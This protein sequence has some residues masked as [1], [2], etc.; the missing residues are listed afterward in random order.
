MIDRIRDRETFVRLR[1]D[2]N[3]VRMGP[4]WCSYVY[5]PHMTSTHVA[6]SIGRNVGNAV[7]RNQLRRRAK[8]ALSRLELPPG[9]LLIGARPEAAE[10]T[11][12]QIHRTL[13]NLMSQATD[14]V[15]AS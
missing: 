1:R 9:L 11:F 3:R 4:L 15:V 12:A 10:L 7:V 8:D 2:G 5:D 13:G 14:R 6:F